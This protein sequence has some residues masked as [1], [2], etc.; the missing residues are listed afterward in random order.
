MKTKKI[1]KDICIIGA[2][3][4]GLTAGLFASR[5]ALETCIIAKDIG[6]QAISAPIENY[7]GISRIS[8]F[9]FAQHVWTQVRQYGCSLFTDEVAAIKK[10]E[11]GFSV[12]TAQNR[13]FSCRAIILACGRVPKSLGVPGEKELFGNGVEYSRTDARA[14]QGLRVAIIGGGASAV[15]SGLALSEHA[16][17]IYIIHRRDSFSA[18]AADISALKEKKNIHIV[19]S[20]AVTSIEGDAQVAAVNI[21]YRETDEVMRIAVER[22]LISVGLKLNLS[23]LGNL[24][25]QDKKGQ[26]IIT[27][28]NETSC[29]GIF[30]A[31]DATIIPFHQVVISAGEGA[32]AALSAYRFLQTQRGARS[33]MMDWE[34][35]V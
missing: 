26:I 22:V 20:S 32:K 19:F 21:F 6:G 4:A 7:P 27:H 3:P 23:F 14:Y 8:G 28:Q 30:A 31:G 25:S 15:Q 13:F 29:P 5:R 18:E 16:S 12:H 17:D 24:V 34:H 11:E 1:T 10:D 2:G 35:K 33:M 9:D